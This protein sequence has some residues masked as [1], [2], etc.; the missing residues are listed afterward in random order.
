MKLR[1]YLWEHEMT[2][3]T[4]ADKTGYNRSYLSQIMH[5]NIKPGKRCARELEKATGGYITAQELLDGKF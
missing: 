5:G 4:F 3:G 1:T 2:L